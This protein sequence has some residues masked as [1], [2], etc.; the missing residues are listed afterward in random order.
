MPATPGRFVGLSAPIVTFAGGLH[1]F[2]AVADR[3]A[4]VEWLEAG[5]GS[6]A[7]VAD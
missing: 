1:K 2:T 4:E 5:D 3:M 7:E 6:P